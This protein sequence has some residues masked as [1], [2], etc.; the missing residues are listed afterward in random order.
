MHYTMTEAGDSS[1]FHIEIISSQRALESFADRIKSEKLIAFDLEADSLHHYQARVCLLQFSAGNE[2]VIIDPLAVRD[3]RPLSG[4]MA[5]PSIRKISHGADY[6]VRMLKSDFDIDVYNLF[7]TMI[8]CQLLGD[9]EVGLASAIK[10]RFGTELDKKYQK[11]DWSIRPLSDEMLHYAAYDCRYLIPL[12]HQITWEL[13]EK[14]RLAW[15]EEESELVARFVPAPSREDEP[16]FLRF[17]GFMKLDRRTL[18]VLEEI[19]RFR[20]QEAQ[21]R[22]CPTFKVLSNAAIQEIAE[23]KPVTVLD[24]EN[25]DNLSPR[26]LPRYGSRLLHAV[27]RGM[28]IPEGKLPQ[29][30]ARRIQEKNPNKALLLP[31]LKEWREKKARELG[32]SAGRLINNAMLEHLAEK[33]PRSTMDLTYF[34]DLR[35]WQAQIFGDEIIELLKEKMPDTH[36]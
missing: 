17:K 28:A 4:I 27:A 26:L 14:N 9:E 15:A 6:D 22:D 25:I 2:T 34:E 12:Y 5:D 11:A 3:M 30:P 35:R 19:L 18:A 13:I 29:K 36:S 23:K 32:V 31:E 24:L 10:N 7:D 33:V 1:R 20:D 8:A 21:D 16:L